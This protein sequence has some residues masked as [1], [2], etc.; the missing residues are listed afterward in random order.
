MEEKDEEEKDD[1]EIKR[2][3]EDSNKNKMTVLLKKKKETLWEIFG[4]K[5]TTNARLT[6]EKAKTSIQANLYISVRLKPQ[7][8]W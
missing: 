6:Q 1:W 3:S 2:V 7:E 4:K 5:D 8:T